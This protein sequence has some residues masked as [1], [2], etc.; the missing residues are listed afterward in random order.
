MVVLPEKLKKPHRL[1]APVWPSNASKASIIVQRTLFLWQNPLTYKSV[2]MMAIPLILLGGS[3]A[4]GTARPGSDWDLFLVTAD[5]ATRDRVADR[6]AEAHLDLELVP[7][8]FVADQVLRIAYGPVRAL[9]VLLDDAAGHGR[10]IV[11]ATQQAYA[12]GPPPLAASERRRHAADL[13][14]LLSKVEAY[15]DEPVASAALD[16]FT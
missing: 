11:A 14:R 4:A 12:A 9:R 2:P 5:G 10:A 7:A 3:R 1:Q 6:Y 8:P 15:A 13:E 16:L